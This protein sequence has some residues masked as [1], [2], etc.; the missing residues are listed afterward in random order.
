MQGDVQSDSIFAGFALNSQL[1]LESMKI[2]Y[3][4]TKPVDMPLVSG[5]E[6]GEMGNC[7]ALDC[8]FPVLEHLRAVIDEIDDHGILGCLQFYAHLSGSPGVEKLIGDKD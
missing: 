6:C 8:K 3:R 5:V 2:G 7:V 1:G 4:I